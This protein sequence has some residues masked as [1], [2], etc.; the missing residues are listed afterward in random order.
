M[1]RA[2]N[3]RPKSS[4]GGSATT[5]TG[6]RVPT[7]NTKC[8]G[9]GEVFEKLKMCSACG[10][11][12]YCSPACQ[13]A[14]WPEHKHICKLILNNH[15]KDDE[16]GCNEIL[17]SREFGGLYS[18][19]QWRFYNSKGPGVLLVKLSHSY[20]SFALDV[21]SPP[22]ESGPLSLSFD[23]VLVDKLAPLE[24]ELYPDPS[25]PRNMLQGQLT[26]RQKCVPSRFLDP[27]RAIW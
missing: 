13:R 2:S 3:E 22:A 26:R 24:Q 19:I 27:T 11:A 10:G 7:R 18:L 1:K 9:C 17:Y 4:L 25:I 8:Y 5:T 12:S 16:A 20:A 14:A 23:Y 15:S 21:P 6:Y